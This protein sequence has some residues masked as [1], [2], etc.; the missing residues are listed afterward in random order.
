MTP[1]LNYLRRKINLTNFLFAVLSLI[2][3]IPNTISILAPNFIW[4]QLKSNFIFPIANDTF[5]YFARAN[6]ILLG[7][8]TINNPYFQGK[9]NGLGGY[10]FL[11]EY[12]LAFLSFITGTLKLGYVLYVIIF[13]LLT[14]NLTKSIFKI[15]L[16]KSE[17]A[18]FTFIA[19]SFYFFPWWYLRPVA[20]S[21][22]ITLYLAI[23]TITH[24][25][26]RNSSI[27][28][29]WYFLSCVLGLA[30]LA[31]PIVAITI[32]LIFIFLVVLNFKNLDI[33]YLIWINITIN[34]V[35]TSIWYFTVNHP[36]NITIKET[37]WRTGLIDSRFPGG[38]NGIVLG[39][40]AIIL[41]II[42]MKNY[43]FNHTSIFLMPAILCCTFLGMNHQVFTGKHGYNSAYGLNLVYIA[44]LIMVIIFLNILCERAGKFN[45]ILNSLIVAAIALSVVNYIGYIKE[46]KSNVPMNLASISK[47]LTESEYFNK[48]DIKVVASSPLVSSQI[49]IYTNDKSLF[50]KEATVFYPV[51][52][53]EIIERALLN[54][55]LFDK[56]SPTASFTEALFDSHFNNLR[57][58]FYLDNQAKLTLINSELTFW[59]SKVTESAALIQKNPEEYIKKFK[60][61]GVLYNSSISFNKLNLCSKVYY[62]DF[63][64]ICALKY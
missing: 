29:N 5:Q 19:V 49:A 4:P 22:G 10:T 53:L 24:Q 21:T 47:F 1:K 45:Y 46:L 52:N 23:L 43:K 6:A 59:T 56:L 9:Y 25:I 36:G 63:F 33:R 60:L 15:Y 3:V 57:L 37:L 40:T 14:Y 30:W 16:V 41:Y 13:V 42:I 39:S 26:I 11:G 50:S 38:I 28:R 61:D 35:S 18:S 58:R 48:N 17:L 62:G 12:W 8:L 64:N 54:D 20:P 7:N 32:L 31:Q 2:L 27:A 55:Y 34:L 44:S 51:S